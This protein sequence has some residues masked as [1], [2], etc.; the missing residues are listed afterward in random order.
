M[1]CVHKCCLDTQRY[2][3]DTVLSLPSKLM[4]SLLSNCC[5]LFTLP[6]LHDLLSKVTL[7][8]VPLKCHLLVHRSCT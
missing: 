2:L 4:P 8:G 1:M 7:S 6:D 5:D 3:R